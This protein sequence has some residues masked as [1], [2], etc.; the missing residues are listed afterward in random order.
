M[1][2]NVFQKFLTW[3]HDWN[4]NLHSFWTRI[5]EFNLWSGRSTRVESIIQHWNSVRAVCKGLL[6][7]LHDSS[8]PCPAINWISSV[9]NCIHHQLQSINAHSTNFVPRLHAMVHPFLNIWHCSRPESLCSVYGLLSRNPICTKRFCLRKQGVVYLRVLGACTFLSFRGNHCSTLY[10]TES[11]CD[12]PSLVDTQS[13]NIQ[14]FLQITRENGVRK[15]VSHYAEVG[16]MILEQKKWRF[17]K[18]EDVVI[19]CMKIQMLCSIKVEGIGGILFVIKA[20]YLS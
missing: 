16:T 19:L 8:I 20:K 3:Y 11:S 13:R 6:L 12:G 4:E 10:E 18:V 7:Y 9:A 14:I 2:H 15:R 17:M 5:L 1:A